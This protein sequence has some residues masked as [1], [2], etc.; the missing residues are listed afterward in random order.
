MIDTLKRTAPFLAMAFL[1]MLTPVRAETPDLHLVER[2]LNDTIS[3]HAGKGAD[4]VGDILTFSNPVYDA[5][6][7]QQLGSD[8]GYCVRV[9]VGKSY[10]C[11]WTLQL[12]SG[13]ITVDGPFFDSSDSTLAITGGSGRYAGAS[14]EMS[15][16][17]R[18]A[19]ST[20]YDFIYHL[21]LS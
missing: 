20:S 19:K 15:L 1:A 17:A 5:T 8:Q 12:S 14:G 9:I 13:Q 21:R 4:N 11:H 3:V 7:T 10:E 6:N 16:H 2:A 18:D